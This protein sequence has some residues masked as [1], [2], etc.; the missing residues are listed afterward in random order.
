MRVL[1]VETDPAIA[2]SAA[3]IMEIEGHDVSG[4]VNDV[5]LARTLAAMRPDVAFLDIAL[6]GQDAT[7][8]LARELF[9]NHGVPSIF[10]GGDPAAADAHAD[11]VIACLPKPYQANDMVRSLY[12]ADAYFDDRRHI[13]ASPVLQKYAS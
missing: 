6:T 11:M 12:M 3:V 9:D 8:A 13:L 10:V 1:L 7:L 4:P 5:D 2:L